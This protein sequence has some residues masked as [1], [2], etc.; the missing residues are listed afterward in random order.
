MATR[1]MALSSFF[2][3]WNATPK[4]T[5]PISLNFP[6]YSSIHHHHYH[7]NDELGLYDCSR[8]RVLSSLKWTVK[9]E[10][11]RRG[12][13]AKC[14][15]AIQDTDC[16]ADDEVY[17]RRSLEIARKAVGHTSPNP[18]VGCVI[19]KNG[20]I[21]GEGFH[22]KAGQ[23][24]AEV[25]ALR[26]AGDL[27]ENATAYVSLEPCNHHG[28]TPPCT[29]ALIKAKVKRVVIGM[30]DPNPIVASKGVQRLRDAGIDVTV[31]MEEDSCR[32]LNEAYIH[33]IL[34]GKPLLT[35][36]YSLSVNGCFVDQVGE[37]AADAGGYY[38][39]LLQ[40]YNAVLISPTSSSGEFE[41]PASKELGAK[42]PLWIILPNPDGS[43]NIPRIT[44]ATTEVV[45][46][47][48]KE[49]TVAEKGIETVVVD[50]L[51]LG[52]ILDY[53]KNQGLNSVLWDVRGELGVHEELL[54]E[55]IEQKLLQKYVV[56]MLPQ[57]KDCQ[58]GRWEAWFK[59]TA[60]SLKLK[61]LQ[62]RICGE[63]VI[64]E[65]NF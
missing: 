50:Q 19:V 42:Q 51:S 28:R 5:P 41:I 21:V 11:C 52:N 7:H 1:I 8:S 3:L 64:L 48:D 20:K 49:A 53:C 56:E 29:E 22:P 59:S 10:R 43:V 54:K 57:W 4:F 45:I 32:K 35:L 65:G 12:H 25:F 62:P 46:L 27:A 44:D 33:Q 36:R 18:M 17:M 61:S 37:G 55:G 40:E 24:H 38:S 15:G 39:Q 2:S 14:V 30:V 16:D 23:P 34:T 6:Q 47:T 58:S 60:E 26:E 13:L 63:S 31:R 9:S